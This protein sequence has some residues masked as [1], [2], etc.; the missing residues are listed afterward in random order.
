MRAR[1]ALPI[2]PPPVCIVMAYFHSLLRLRRSELVLMPRLALLH[3]QAST[4]ESLSIIIAI[5]SSRKARSAWY[6]Q[7]IHFNYG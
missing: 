6:E 4:H 5:N 2:S 3:A 1:A 7:A